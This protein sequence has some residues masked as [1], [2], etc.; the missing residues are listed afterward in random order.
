MDA[1]AGIDGMA[2]EVK[3]G[4]LVPASFLPV[5]TRLEYLKTLLK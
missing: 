3:G 1:A 4:C 5:P 2:G